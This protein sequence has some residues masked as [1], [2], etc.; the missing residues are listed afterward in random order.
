MKSVEAIL[1]AKAYDFATRINQWENSR[2]RRAHGAPE[3][4]CAL[5]MAYAYLSAA[6][7]VAQ[8]PLSEERGDKP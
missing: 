7:I 3:T 5:A 2:K 6:D 4:A 8:A 1:R